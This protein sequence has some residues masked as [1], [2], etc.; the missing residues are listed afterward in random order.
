[1]LLPALAA[2]AI[3]PVEERQIQ[4]DL[5]PQFTKR[6]MSVV[7]R[8]ANTSENQ[9]SFFEGFESRDP[10]AYGFAANAFLPKGWSQFS[11]QGNKHMGS[12]D[13]YWDL[14]WLT[15]SNS[16]ALSLPTMHQTVAYEGECFAFIMS[17][18][19]WGGKEPYPDLGL[20]YATNHPQD[21]WLVS[22]MITPQDEEWLYFKL[23]FRPGWSLYDR[24]AN[25]F[26]GETNLLEVYITEDE[27]TADSQWTKLWSLKDYITENYTQEQLRADLTNINTIPYESIFV[28]VS[29][30]VGKKVKVAFRYYGV[31]GLGMAIDNVSLGI[32][33]PKP[34]YTIPTGFF[35]QQTI[36]PTMNELANEP[37]LLIPFGTEAT[38]MNTSEDILTNQ[39]DY[40]GA[41]GEKLISTDK[42]LTTPAYELGHKYTTP[43][44]TGMFESRKAVYSSAF[45]SMQAG[46]RLSGK[47]KGGYEGQLGVA[48]YDFLDPTCKFTQSSTHIAFYNEVNDQWEMLLGR[49]PN[50]ID[51]QGIGNVYP[52]TP[53]EYGFDYV[54]IFAQVKG[55]T[56]GK[57]SDNT[58]LVLTVYRLPEN[59]FDEAAAVIGHSVLTGADINAITDLDGGYKNLRFNLEVPVVTKSN[60]L[61]MVV[62][63]NIDGTDTFVFPYLKSADEKI[64]GNSVVYMMIYDTEENGGTYDTF[65]NLNAFGQTP[66]NHFAGLTMSLG[67]VYSYMEALDYTGDA[68]NV[69]IEGG[70]FD[71]DIRSM[72]TP[73]QWAVT[74]NGYSKSSWIT[75]SAEPDA[76]DEDLYHA[77][78]KFAEN[79]EAP[80]EAEVYI[81]QPGSR[82][83]LKVTQDG[84]A[85]LTEISAGSAMTVNVQGG[86]VTVGGVSGEVS[87]Y[88]VTGLKVAGA[89]AEGAVSFNTSSLA[90][91]VYIVRCGNAVAK[92]VL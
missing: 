75:V 84:D 68:I 92:I 52:S 51:I 17:D 87:I 42:N 9:N 76:A 16:G 30:Y 45:T 24:E 25:D 43:L 78:I 57:V 61:V 47:G 72:Y 34:S 10:D 14:T 62:P 32:P 22:P 20:D 66:Q 80:R 58:V 19:M 71:L 88:N 83:A 36:D 86:T 44:L 28:R 56:D 4:K 2:M 18:V 53:T 63:F 39:W 37:Q 40:E 69:P 74:D 59:E 11:R 50:T 38:W 15:L 70:E 33:M 21:E 27:G 12:S 3:V 89:M 23:Q 35:K 85:S 67:T 54:D 6:P 79:T 8:V 82:I 29:D 60:I 7:A 1:M 73:D 46:G 65:Y 49:M 77:K 41:D 64:W 5:N 13:G 55:G 81:S 48:T 31:N 91:G 26:S 90:H